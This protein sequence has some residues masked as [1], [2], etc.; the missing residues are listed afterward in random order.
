MKRRLIVLTLVIA[1]ALLAGCVDRTP[2]PTTSPST[3]SPQPTTTEPSEPASSPSTPSAERNVNTAAA[4]AVIGERQA[5]AV[6]DALVRA[7]RP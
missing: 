3:S 6:A 2:D 5:T 1:S 4:G 7:D